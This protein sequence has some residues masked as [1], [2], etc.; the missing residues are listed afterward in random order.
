[1]LSPKAQ[2]NLKNAKGYFEEHLSVGDY[3]AENHSVTGE[4]TGLGAAILGLNGGVTRDAFI[5]LCENE[6]PVSRELL[7]LRRNTVRR[8]ANDGQVANRRV[9]YDFTFSP[10]KSVS[11]AALVLGDRRI[12]IAHNAAVKI[13]ITELEAFAAARV[14]R[15]R[16]NTDRRTGNIAAAL[17]QHDTS[18]ALDPHLHTHCIIFNGTHDP[19][20]GCW[21]ALQNYEMLGAQKYVENVYYHELARALRSFGYTIQNN[22]R[23]DFEIAEISR[24][25]CERFSKRHREID[26]KT[27]AFL[28][29][30]QEKLGRNEAAIREHIAHKDRARKTAGIG[31]ERLRHLWLGQLS[32]D[33]LASM[34]QSG[35]TEPTSERRFSAAEAVSWAEG[36]LFERRS[37]VREHELWRQALSIARGDAISLGSIKEETASRPYLRTGDDKVAH[38]DVLAREWNIVQAA[39]DGIGRHPRL[40][41][42]TDATAL[43]EDQQ[44][45]LA[46]I[47]KSRNFITLFRGGAGTGKSFVLRAVQ[48]AI[49]ESKRP[50]IVVAPQRQQV[51]D[52]ARDGLTETQTVKECLQRRDLK[53]RSVVIVDEAGQLDGRQ[54]IDLIRFVEERGGRLLLCGDTRQHGPVEASDAL[55]AIER[56][57]GLRAAE[58]SHIRRQDPK[59]GRTAGERK[60]IRKYRAAVEAAAAGQL[61]RSLEKLEKIGAIAE[62]SLVDQNT[63]LC[64]AYLDLV[65]RGESAIVVSQT[66]AEVREINGAIRERL[67]QL[68]ALSSDEIEVTALEQLDLT[69]AQKL[70]GRHYPRDSVLVFNRDVHGCARGLQAKFIA[71]TLNRLVFEAD[72]KIRHLPITAIDRVNVCQRRV[73]ALSRGDKIQLKANSVAKDGRKLANGEVVIVAQIKPSGAIRLEDGRVLPPTYRQFVRGY[74]VTSYGSQGKT[75]D[76]V[77]FSD[78]AVRAATNA[79]QW[80]VTISRGRKSIQIF[81]PDKQQLRAAILRNGERELALDLLPAR[82]RR[83][84][85]R[86]Q[87]LRSLGRGREFARRICGRAMRSWSN[88]LMNA[89]LKP[90]DEIRTQQTNR[91]VR[92]NVLAA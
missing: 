6:H 59:R 34:R 14:R 85:I 42:A 36:H 84:G 62:C 44:G 82:A 9:F 13:A 66:R 79:Q 74:A 57:S 21:K 89:H 22:A 91:S 73:V 83:H 86:R 65:A 1:M 4:W 76:H 8:S 92:P 58:L 46:V 18:R 90:T 29:S 69:T 56:Y 61:G 28:D 80:Y 78:S 3:Y 67:R 77:L 53:E 68:G 33:E 55:R 41:T 37:V 11:V 26:E 48:K 16:T 17:F 27:R 63:Q 64:D 40:A 38:R 25:L 75:V 60:R 43:A 31:S 39:R 35:R 5:A 88:G 47:L 12:V 19:Q 50:C 10:P 2:T 54:L 20:E 51:I 71:L 70:D 81:T 72:G 45:A 52:L 23:G 7:T 87:M 24:D 30:H 49:F 32:A 15:G